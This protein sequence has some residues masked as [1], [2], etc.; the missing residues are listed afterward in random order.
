MHTKEYLISLNGKG[1]FIHHQ[2][3]YK[4]SPT[5]V[6]LHDSLGCISLWRDFPTKL[7]E[8]TQCNILVYDRLGYG[9]SKPM[10]DVPRPVNYLEAEAE[11]LNDLL[12]ELSIEQPILF[13]HSDG[14]S[15]ALLTAAKYPDR[16][17][18]VISEAAHVFVEEIT[19]QGIREAMTAYQTT[20]L[21]E[22][23][24][25]YHGDNTDILFRAWTQTWT[26]DDFR[27]WNIESFL[28][29]IT[30]PVLV[31]Q[32]INDEFGSLA[33]VNSIVNNVSGSVEKALIEGSGH[34]PHKETP[35][36]TLTAAVGF[37]DNL[38]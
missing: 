25:K 15:I 16:I 20:N 13:G 23:L 30:C 14:G 35:E 32:G 1:L 2:E 11:T 19:L 31:L 17:K 28:P 34:T 18:A 26:R 7:G 5:I 22:R 38:K 33:Q 4:D 3:N 24:E 8:L 12:T 6:F 37:I 36:E 9:R 27:E 29:A 21:K 10:P